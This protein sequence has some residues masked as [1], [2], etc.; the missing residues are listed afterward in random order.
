ML[1]LHLYHG[2]TSPDQELNDWGEDGPYVGP[3]SFVTWTYGYLKLQTDID[4]H[5]LHEKQEDDMVHHNGKWYGDFE[6]RFITGLEEAN[7][8]KDAIPLDVFFAKQ[9]QNWVHDESNNR[10]VLEDDSKTVFYTEELECGV[11]A[12]DNVVKLY[13]EFKD[14]D[15][16]LIGS[17][18]AI[19][20]YLLDC[21]DFTTEDREI[22]TEGIFNVI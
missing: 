22:I 1:Y 15:D 4:T 2:R 9:R 21:S 10:V 8:M 3:I 19:D 16:D 18:G 6:L 7:E 5:F 17:D 14:T 11:Q 13:H 20:S 12:I